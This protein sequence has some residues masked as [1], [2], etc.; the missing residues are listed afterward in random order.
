[1]AGPEGTEMGF[2]Q[3]EGAG[4]LSRP[5]W[6]FHIIIC[7][8]IDLRRIEK[9][10]RMTELDERQRYNEEHEEASWTYRF[11]YHALRKIPP[12]GIAGIFHQSL[13][14]EVQANMKIHQ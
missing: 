11:L 13:P 1:M 10:L 8:H 9:D 6:L 2:G 4:L 5:A 14:E 12:N 3:E 7:G